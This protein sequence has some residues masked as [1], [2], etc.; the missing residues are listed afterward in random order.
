[1][2]QHFIKMNR[3]DNPTYYSLIDRHNEIM[4]EWNRIHNILH[5]FRFPR[6]FPFFQKKR[7][8]STSEAFR[9]LQ[10]RFVHW[11]KD[12][13]TFIID[14]RLIFP[15]GADSQ[16]TFLHV[17]A[18]LRDTRSRLDSDMLLLLNDFSRTFEDINNQINFVVALLS[19]IGTFAGLV[20]TLL[21]MR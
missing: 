1:M 15:S 7:L 17:T 9:Q 3:D 19:F 5:T 8:R 21:N 18:L 12:T 13:Y 20:A 16:M 6:F 11:N 2:A 10:D 4:V 14:P